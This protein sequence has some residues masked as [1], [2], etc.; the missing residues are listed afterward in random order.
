LVQW[1][2]DERLPVGD[3]NIAEGG[4]HVISAGVA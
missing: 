4:Q 3:S 2:L 1:R